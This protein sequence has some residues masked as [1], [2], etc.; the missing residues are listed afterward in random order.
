MRSVF[1]DA[2]AGAECLETI[3]QYTMAISSCR[4]DLASVQTMVQ[5]MIGG[6]IRPIL[7]VYTTSEL[8]VSSIIEVR[9]LVPQMITRGQMTYTVRPAS[10]LLRGLKPQTFPLQLSHAAMHDTFM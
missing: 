10:M 9:P 4:L 5:P 2:A 8:V 1:T 3:E 6:V 7:K